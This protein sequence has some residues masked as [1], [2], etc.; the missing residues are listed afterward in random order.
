MLT[1][2]AAAA[3]FVLAGTSGAAA[4]C[5]SYP[6]NLSTG[7]TANNTARALCLQHELGR[8]TEGDAQRAQ[9]EV[10]L[11][12]LRIQLEQQQ[13]MLLHRQSLPAWPVL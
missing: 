11:G 8:L 7:Y 9:I 12:N 2:I 6:D 5:A 13:Q 10:E 4:Y 1:R 3:L